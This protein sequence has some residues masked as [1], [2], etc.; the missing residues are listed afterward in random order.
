MGI[1]SSSAAPSI[2]T[3]VTA[4]E[5]EGDPPSSSSSSPAAAAAATAPMQTSTEPPSATGLKG[6]QW[7]EPESRCCKPLHHLST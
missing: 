7:V 4:R 1:V 6:K 2:T 5:L 3:A